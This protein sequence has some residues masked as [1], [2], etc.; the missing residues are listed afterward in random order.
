MTGTLGVLTYNLFLDSTH[1]TI[2]GNGSSGTGIFS[3]TATGPNIGTPVYRRIPAR[4]N[5]HVGAYSDVIT[6]TVTF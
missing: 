4:Q 6:I 5:A 3:G 2:W 1:L